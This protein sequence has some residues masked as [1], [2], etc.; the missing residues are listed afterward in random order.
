MGGVYF[1][2]D[3]EPIGKPDTFVFMPHKI[4]LSPFVDFKAEME[5]KKEFAKY[6]IDLLRTET[7]NEASR[8]MRNR[9]GG[10]FSDK[11]KALQKGTINLFK[12]AT[13]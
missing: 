7:D 5:A 12:N 2:F 13:F 11:E 6:P 4:D 8:N 9:L 1:Y 3:A 10:Y